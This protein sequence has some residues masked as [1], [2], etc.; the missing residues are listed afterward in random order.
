MLAETCKAG[1]GWPTTLGS[2]HPLGLQQQ[3]NSTCWHIH[4]HLAINYMHRNG[5]CWLQKRC[6]KTRASGAPPQ[7]SHKVACS[8]GAALISSVSCITPATH[9]HNRRQEATGGCICNTMPHCSARGSSCRLRSAPF[10]SS[11]VPIWIQ[12][13]T[14][15]PDPRLPGR[16]NGNL[17][18]STQHAAEA[19]QLRPQDSTAAGS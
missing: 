5:Q 3:H 17:T 1:Q 7:P 12:F 19:A 2:Q 6:V 15:N 4:M 10:L 9:M 14:H 8:A 18:C 16:Q 13:H 11:S